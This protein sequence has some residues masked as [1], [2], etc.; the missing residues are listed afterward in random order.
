MKLVIP[1]AGRGTRLGKYEL[2]KG[3][4]PV[5]GRPIVFGI[6]DY[7]KDCIDDVIIVVS[8]VNSNTYKTYFENYYKGQVNVRFIEQ[9]TSLNGA[10]M[11]GTLAAVNSVFNCIAD[12]G[13]I[14]NWCD[15]LLEDEI[16]KNL[17]IDKSQVNFA[18]TTNNISC[19]WELSGGAFT[20]RGSNIIRRGGLIGIFIINQKFKDV[21]QISEHN[22]LCEVEFLEELNPTNFVPL[23]VSALID[24]GDEKKYSPKFRSSKNLHQRPH[25]SGSSIILGDIVL[26]QQDMISSELE[27]NWLKSFETNVNTPEVVSLYP[28]VIERVYGNTVAELLD[29]GQ[30]SAHQAIS[31]GF[32]TLSSITT[33]F[34]E[35][36]LRS[37]IDEK[38]QYFDTVL[39]KLNES[40]FLRGFSFP[41]CINGISCQD[42]RSLLMSAF[43]VI[44]ESKTRY[45]FIHGDLQLSNI[46]LDL[47]GRT[48]V[49]DPRPVFGSMITLGDLRYDI[50]KLC[51]GFVGGWDWFC[52]NNAT[53]F[54]DNDSY[55][56][57]SNLDLDELMIRQDLFRK[58]LQE[59]VPWINENDI[60]IIHSII[61]LRATTYVI[62]DTISSN[63]AFLNGTYLLNKALNE[64]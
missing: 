48:I 21:Y 15:V 61:W 14:L 63:Y 6:I 40:D 53:Y 17:A 46:M 45:G 42:P 8:S 43:K 59:H 56:L 28:L 33:G 38:K 51:Y 64:R 36:C 10:V 18:I 32:N 49:I 52:Q 31:I 22:N 60:D 34:A 50:A 1:V 41:L 35:Q 58:N 37:F 9:L 16:V 11:N 7:W 3:L 25:G 30:I 4:L 23:P 13:V 44:S 57:N 5:N 55:T 47:E 24:I 2:P 62:N 12:E 20:N 19:R 26:K 39:N 54:F 29:G 27:A